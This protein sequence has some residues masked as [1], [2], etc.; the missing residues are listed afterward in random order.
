M[1]QITL[2]EA[3]ME[4]LSRQDPR[5]RRN[6]GYQSLLVRLQKNTDRSTG[7]LTLTATDLERIPRYAFDYGNGGWEGRLMGIFQRHLA[8]HWAWTLISGPNWKAR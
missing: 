8:R 6:G 3:E 5:T 1:R 4:V 2:N 7:A